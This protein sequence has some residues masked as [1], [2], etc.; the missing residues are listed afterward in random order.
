M[1]DYLGWDFQMPAV[2]L[3]KQIIQPFYVIYKAL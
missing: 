1:D 3:E 2:D